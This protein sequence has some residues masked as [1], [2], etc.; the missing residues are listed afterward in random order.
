MFLII[1]ETVQVTPMTFTLN[2]VLLNV[3]M[4]ITLA[5]TV[6]HDFH[7]LALDLAN[8]YMA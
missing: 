3:Y 8:V 6:G 7:D 5:T 4:T 2:V 1:S